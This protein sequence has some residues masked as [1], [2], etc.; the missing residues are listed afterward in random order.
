MTARTRARSYT[1]VL[2]PM[3]PPPVAY[4]WLV[5]TDLG[6]SFHASSAEEGERLGKLRTR[7]KVTG[8]ALYASVERQLRQEWLNGYGLPL[9][10]YSCD[11]QSDSDAITLYATFTHRESGA[12][13]ECGTIWFSDDGNINQAGPFELQ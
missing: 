11:V 3:R 13:I 5:T 9:D 4:R 12:K 8:A 6:D 2:D 7:R 1:V 10:Q